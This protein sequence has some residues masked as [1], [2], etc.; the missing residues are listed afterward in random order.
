M[1]LVAVTRV[2]NEDD[3]VEAFFRHHAALVDHHLFLDNGSVDRTLEILGALFVEGEKLSV[4]HNTAAHFAESIANTNLFEYAATTLGADWV[5]FLDT[6]EFLDTRAAP[7]GLRGA[8]AALPADAA[9]VAA[10]T[11]DYLDTPADDEADL[12][13]PRRMRQRE[14]VAQFSVPRPIIRAALAGR[15]TVISSGNH[16]VFRG[17]GAIPVADAPN[18]RVAHYSRRGPW[19]LVAK[20]LIGRLKVLAA[21]REV[22]DSGVSAHYNDIFAMI[23]DRPEALLRDP[24][25]VRPSHAERDLVDD[26][27]A[28]LGGPLRHTRPGD[29]AMKA[30]RV[31]AGYAELLAAQHG[32]LISSNEGIR[33]QTNHD[34]AYWTRLF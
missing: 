12:L 22:A 8:L 20:S 5:V 26:P 19:H 10:G 14:R 29:A 15:G 23:R 13:V 27:I 31:L 3:I 24:G 18:L 21:G 6:D 25:F 34:A 33:L 4:L 9:G 11:I 30:V 1:R 2:F 16:T 17:G 28:Y 32:R 7:E